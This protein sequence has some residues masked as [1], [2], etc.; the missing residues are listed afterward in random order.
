MVFSEDPEDLAAWTPR[1]PGAASG[2]ACTGAAGVGWAGTRVSRVS[3]LPTVS[4]CTP[5][6]L[7]SLASPGCSIPITCRPLALVVLCW[8]RGGGDH[9]EEGMSQRPH[10]IVQGPGSGQMD[11]GGD[12]IL[13]EAR[14]QA[15]AQ[16]SSP[17]SVAC[18]R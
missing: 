4:H 13:G 11:R 2:P 8:R 3:A 12:S 17:S 6:P 18:S 5:G 15:K 1:F 10:C 14:A 7:S 16:G 9:W